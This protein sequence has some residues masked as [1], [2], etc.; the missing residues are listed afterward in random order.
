MNLVKLF[1]CLLVC[2]LSLGCGETNQEAPK[3]ESD[4]DTYRKSEETKPPKLDLSDARK[5]LSDD[6]IAAGWVSLFDGKTLFGWRS[7]SEMNWRVEDGVLTADDGEPG[8]LLTSVPFSDYE[9]RCE[10][11]VADQGN[12]GVFL[13]TSSK[14]KSP[15]TDCYELNICDT[16]DSHVTGSLVAR[17]VP[18]QVQ[19]TDGKW[20]SFH[21]TLDGPQIKVVLN[22]EQVLDFTDKPETLREIGYIGLQYRVGKIEFRHVAV[23]PLKTTP[24]FN[25]S[26]LTGWREVPGSKSKFAVQEGTIH[27]T[28]GLGFLETE[29]TFGNFTLQAEVKTNG[30]NLNSGIFFRGMPGKASENLNGYEFQIHHGFKNEDRTQPIDQGTGAIFRRSPARW[31]AGND[32]E[33]TALT[34]IAYGSQFATWVNGVPVVVWQDKRAENENPRKGRRTAAGHLALQGHDPTTDLN[35]RYIRIQELPAPSTPE[36]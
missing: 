5:L 22:D 32:R 33:W 15:A 7:N 12:S 13:R 16:H 14:P 3:Q 35:F 10:F 30:E 18:N 26:D 20:N 17:A 4:Q 31:V 23:K 19:K 8:L 27:A 25:S 24:L 34:L 36:K 9:F 6:E 28:N 29:K 2:S 21:V 11:R 1:V